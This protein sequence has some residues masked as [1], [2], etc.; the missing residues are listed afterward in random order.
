MSSLDRHI[1]IRLFFIKRTLQLQGFFQLL[2][3]L[4]GGQ[5][6]IVWIIGGKYVSPLNIKNSERFSTMDSK[7]VSPVLMYRPIT[8]AVVIL[9]TK[10]SR[11]V[12]LIGI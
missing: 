11:R 10:A 4:R 8:N 7:W 3:C 9:L 6:E 12:V 1:N 5:N 2:I